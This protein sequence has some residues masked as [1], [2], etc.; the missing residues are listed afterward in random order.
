MSSIPTG[1]VTVS[2]LMD[3][4]GCDMDTAKLVFERADVDGDGKLDVEEIRKY[5]VTCTNLPGNQG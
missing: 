4:L 2:E 3:R 5:C 1:L